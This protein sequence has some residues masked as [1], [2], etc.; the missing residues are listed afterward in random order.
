MARFRIGLPAIVVAA[1]PLLLAAFVL[2]S[3]L[4]PA[5]GDFLAIPGIVLYAALST[6]VAARSVWRERSLKA[7]SLLVLVALTWIAWISLP[8]QRIGMWARLHLEMS[9]YEAEAISEAKQRETLLC[10]QTK[11]CGTEPLKYY[12]YTSGYFLVP[13]MGVLRTPGRIPKLD[14]ETLQ[15]QYGD[16]SCEVKPL[17]AGY[18]WCSMP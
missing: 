6:F 10:A 5:I 9:K 17:A 11:T 12:P 16:M 2:T 3:F 13:T 8:V 7:A 1:F 4:L 18:Y 14:H 15:R